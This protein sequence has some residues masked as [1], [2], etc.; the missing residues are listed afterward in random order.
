MSA[1]PRTSGAPARLSLDLLLVGRPDASQ[2]LRVSDPAEDLD[3][4]HDAVSADDPRVIPGAG[5]EPD[6]LVEGDDLVV[7]R[8]HLVAVALQLLSPGDEEPEVGRL[9]EFRELGGLRRAQGAGWHSEGLEVLGGAL[10]GHRVERSHELLV[11]EQLLEH[12]GV[13]SSDRAMHYRGPGSLRDGARRA[14]GHRGVDDRQR[15][16]EELDVASRFADEVRD[17]ERVADVHDVDLRDVTWRGGHVD[18]HCVVMPRD[19]LED[20]SAD[21]AEADDDNGLAVVHHRAPAVRASR[22]STVRV[23]SSTCLTTRACCSVESPG[24]IGSE[25]AWVAT[26]SEIGKSPE[27]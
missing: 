6:L 9:G 24:N 7:V 1:L 15:R 8:P 21:L 26:C 10:G 5:K 19:E 23:A 4:R 3:V 17:L 2:D 13:L 16:A 27:R 20:R 18:A 22:R 14:D 12:P 25:S 11:A